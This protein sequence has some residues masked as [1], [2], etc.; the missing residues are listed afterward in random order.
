MSVFIQNGFNGDNYDLTHPRT[1]HIRRGT[2]G[3]VTASS[4]ASGFAATNAFNVRLDSAWRPNS[5]PAT[6][7]VLFPGDR[8]LGYVGIGGHDLGT[9]NASITIQITTNGG[10][11][12]TAVDGLNGLAITDDSAIMCLLDPVTVNGYRVRINSAD[13]P[14][15]IATIAGGDVL[16]WPQRAVW[17]DTPITESEQI[18]YRNNT[19]D[20]GVL[21]GAT[22]DSNGLSF[23]AQI[24]NLSETFRT[25]EFRA[26]ADYCNKGEKAF[27]IATRP[28]GYPD[29]VAYAWSSEKVMMTRERPNARNSGS[30][31]LNLNGYRQDF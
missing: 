11:T 26:F 5:V 1:G 31:T 19:S 25:G 20:T 12:W 29:E 14:P 16:E 22:A 6:W 13:A 8:V 18:T 21:I 7:A 15:T 27:F 10:T 23:T 28:G 17:T 30:V 2:T 9:Q 24:D 3:G 4:A